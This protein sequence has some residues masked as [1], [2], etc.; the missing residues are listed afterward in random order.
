MTDALDTARADA[1]DVDVD[2]VVFD[3][4]GVIVDTERVIHEIWSE[5]FATFG[6][7]F[8]LD[9]WR[10]GVGSDHGFDPLAAL[11][12]R[13]SAPLPPSEELLSSIRAKERARAATLGPM[14]GVTGW[15]ASAQRLRLRLG[16][17]SSSPR[18]WIEERLAGA[19]LAG[20]FAT[21]ASP[22][23]GLA[24]KPAPDV[25]LAACERLGVA[26]ARALAIEDSANGLAAAVAAGMR[27]IVVPNAITSGSDFTSASLRIASLADVGL[28]A[29]LARFAAEPRTPRAKESRAPRAQEPRLPGAA[30]LPS[31]P[32]RGGVG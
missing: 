23:R 1:L 16:V 7:S 27:C 21:M 11:G 3:L 25:Y 6:A 17:A 30:G 14:P 22:E 20:C 8:T 26:P 19:G 9:E 4:D 32:S 10:R 28:E 12:E 5:V 31:I 13:S 2:A 29:V 24:A 18:R 15:I